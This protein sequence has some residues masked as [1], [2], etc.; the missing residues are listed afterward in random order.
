MR[1]IK[2]RAWDGEKMHY[3][4]TFTISNKWGSDSEQTISFQPEDWNGGTMTCEVLDQFTGLLDK[5]GKELYEEDLIRLPE[6]RDRGDGK[7][8]DVIALV[9]WCEADLAFF[10]TGPDYYNFLMAA[11]EDDFEIVGN[12][13]ENPELLEVKP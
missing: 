2:F 9:Y 13:Y 5:N 11:V 6:Q 7:R 10:V 1:K 4:K 12:L 3:P 8:D